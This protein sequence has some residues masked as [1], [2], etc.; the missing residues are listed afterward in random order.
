MDENT[1]NTAV[2]DDAEL[3][4]A[5]DREDDDFDAA[6]E[7]QTPK[8]DQPAGEQQ[9]ADQPAAT[10]TNTDPTKQDEGADQPKEGQQAAD[11]PEL[12]TIRYRGQEEQLTRDQLTTLAQKGR[13]YDTVRIERDQ[14]KAERETNA[15]AV[16]LVKNYAQRNGMTVPEYLEWCRKQELMRGG[17]DEQAANQ[18]IQMEK[19]QADLD[20]QE[21]RINELK[22]QQD[23]ILQQNQAVQE[24]RRKDLQDFL[25]A[26]PTCDPKTIPKEVWEKV[27]QGVGL[28]AAY[29]MHENQ[30]LQAELAA[31]RQ[32][33]DNRQRTPGGLSGNS[34]TEL[35]EIDRYWNNDD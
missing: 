1:N 11:Q 19:R 24:A 3:D 6:D 9:P 25:K 27:G 13:D 26:Y 30:R 28:T 22:T 15:A 16:D 34:G 20:A 7:A 8:A 18:T 32:N 23:A 35:D 14:L 2:I 31:E 17:M 33:K 12:F 29:T 4:A 5:W 21:A 10:E